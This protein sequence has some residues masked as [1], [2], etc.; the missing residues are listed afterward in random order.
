MSNVIARITSGAL[1]ATAMLL[2]T[3]AQAAVYQGRFDPIEFEG[4]ASFE[5]PDTCVAVTGFVDAGSSGCGIVDFLNADVTNHGAPPV[6]GTIHFGPQGDVASL[7]QWFEGQLIGIDTG[8]IGPAAGT[9]TF[10]NPDGYLL[11]FNVGDLF[12]DG[13]CEDECSALRTSG[14]SLNSLEDATGSTP[15]TVLLFACGFGCDG[16]QQVGD[17]AIQDPFVRIPEPGSLAL[18]AGGLVA[19]WA[20]RRRRMKS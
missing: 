2:G 5:I 17:P 20:A 19:G 1:L 10:N 13:C 7:L 4:I 3:G 8:D 6:T 12:C 9:G 11:R 16:R 18:I 15:G 14:L